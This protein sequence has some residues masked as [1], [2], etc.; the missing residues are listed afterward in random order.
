VNMEPL[1]H[2]LEEISQTLARQRPTPHPVFRGGLRRQLL[3]REAG[4]RGGAIR[5]AIAA[6]ASAGGALMAV[7]A[8]GVAGAGPFSP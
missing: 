2:D 5:L 1:D 3:E 7:A 4:R 8:L 6:Y